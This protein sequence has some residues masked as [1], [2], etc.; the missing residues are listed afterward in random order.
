MGSAARCL[1]KWQ[2]SL[3]WKENLPCMG[4]NRHCPIN[5]SATR[6]W[7]WPWKG[8]LAWCQAPKVVFAVRLQSGTAMIREIA[9]WQQSLK[10]TLLF[11]GYCTALLKVV[12]EHLPAPQIC[13]G[14]WAL[15]INKWN[16]ARHSFVDLNWSSRLTFLRA[17]GQIGEISFLFPVGVLNRKCYHSVLVGFWFSWWQ[18]FYAT[19]IC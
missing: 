12:C 10:F 13:S 17:M 11:L 6:Y 16:K 15:E 18:S 1:K 4:S 8:M 14:R 2:C 3:C 5:P 7:T 19:E 9:L